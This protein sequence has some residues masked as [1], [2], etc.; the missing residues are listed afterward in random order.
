[1]NA[2]RRAAVLFA[3]LLLTQKSAAAQ[4]LPIVNQES[5]NQI[6][7][8]LSASRLATPDYDPSRVPSQV[9]IITSKD[10]EASGARTL[11]ELLSRQPGVVLFDEI[12]N[13]YQQTLDL[14]GFN[15]TPIPTTIVLVDG[16]KVNEPDFGTI[17][18]QTIPLS[19]IDRI[20]IV[21]GPQTIFGKNA[22]SGII[23]IVKKKGGA[24][25]KAS[26]QAEYGSFNFQRYQ[27]EASG[28]AAGP[29][30]YRL[31]ASRLTELGYRRSAHARIH[32]FDGR[33][34]YRDRDSEASLL[35]H[36]TDDNLQQ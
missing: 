2:Y 19:T 15:A 12:G 6:Q 3:T 30:S 27:A 23:N 4:T 29:L 17:N 35:Y 28:P 24:S 16:V 5:Q 18:F 11:Q 33:L 20:E 7:S 21:P 9:R 34:D 32:S 10:I 22:L 13:G 31:D 25:P 8:I 1:M 14:R 36:C 26:A